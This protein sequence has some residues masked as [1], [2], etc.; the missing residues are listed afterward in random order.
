MG[1]ASTGWIWAV[2]EDEKKKTNRT[3]RTKGL[4]GR[5]WSR[6][7]GKRNNRDS[8][9]FSRALGTD[10]AIHRAVKTQRNISRENGKM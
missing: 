3:H 6:R 1:D 9:L 5:R 4:D 2:L 7:K 8:W 10:G